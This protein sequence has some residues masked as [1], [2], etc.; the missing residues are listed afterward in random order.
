MFFSYLATALHAMR[1]QP[2]FSA[3]KILSL[4]LGLAASILV[5]MHV[6]FAETS[7]SHIENRANTYRMLTHMKIRELNVPY[8]TASSSDAQAT[9]LRADFAEQIPYIARV[10]PTR[11]VF[12]RNNE[13]SENSMFWAEPDAVHIFDLRFIEGEIDGALVAPN[14]VLLSE[15]AVTKYFG[16]ESALGQ[17]LTFGESTDLQVTGVFEDQPINATHRM[18]V[19]VSHATG[20]QLN[21]ENFMGGNNWLTFGGTQTFMTLPEGTGPEWFSANMPAFLERHIPDDFLAL[22]EALGFN[23]S[24][25]PV[26]DIFL[27]PFDNFASPEN[28]RVRTVLYGLMM[29]ATLILVTSCINYVNL[30]LSQI[31]QRSKE[32][33]VRKALGATRTDIIWQ[34]LLESMLLTV[35]AL[36]IALPIVAIAIPVYTNLT[37]TDFVFSDLFTSSL[38]LL[39]LALVLV[40]GA[41]AGIVPA[42]SISKVEAV[43]AMKGGVSRDR[44]G[45]LIRA[46]VTASQFTISSALILLAIATYVQI[47]Y[48]QEMDVGFDKEGLVILDTR[49]NNQEADAFN[50]DALRNDLVQHPAVRS[51]A[52]ANFL[53]PNPPP[54]FQWRLRRSAPNDTVSIVYGVVGTGFV[55]TW[56]LELL[57]GRTFSEQFPADYYPPGSER[58]TADT[59]GAVITDATARR[60]GIESPEAALGEIIM[61]GDMSF[62]VIGVV[63]RFQL[64][65]GMESDQRS[66]GILMGVRMPQRALHIRIDPLQTDAA[67]AHIDATWAV[68]RGNSPINRY[69]F[70]QSLNDI[71]VERNTGLS[72]ASLAA[73]A[74]TIMIAAFGLYALASYATARRTKEVGVRKVLGA[75]SGVIVRLLAWDFVKPVLLACLV[76][77]PLAW[78][79]ID[80]LYSSFA[81]RAPFSFTWYLLV[82][83]GIVVLA[84][85]TVAIQCYRTASADPV[86]S[87]RYE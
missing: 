49:Y 62:R 76:A 46:G 14:T 18:E 67:L 31:S 58:D 28:T 74:I 65:S 17:T 61:I 52:M 4:A 87:L 81:S 13:A 37:A 56:G 80:L 7:N 21:G 57:A 2:I 59:Y 42:L 24:L 36:L 64:A 55:E 83:G 70:S 78:Y 48:L 82:T 8:R 11:A 44:M 38:A 9:H 45:R 19:V 3:I 25:Q 77:W 10:R 6:Q 15:T 1:K 26:T 84:F 72:I 5:V 34:F 22:S 79:G 39:L 75:S 12:S 32:I 71:I 20:V 16:D 50:Y 54:L 85:A 66:I 73:A 47:A 53:A 33:G 86:R 43:R 69:F 41:V 51:V 40:T 63:K 68:H 29:F 30:S 27:N 60:F 23:L 35:I